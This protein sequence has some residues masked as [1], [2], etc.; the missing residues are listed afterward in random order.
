MGI[1]FRSVI[2]IAYKTPIQN[3]H[4]KA[5]VAI[6]LPQAIRHRF[7]VEKPSFQSALQDGRQGAS[8]A[9]FRSGAEI[10]RVACV[11]VHR[12]SYPLGR[13][14]IFVR[15]AIGTARKAPFQNRHFDPVGARLHSDISG[16]AA[17]FLSESVVA[18]C[19]C[20]RI[21]TPFAQMGITF[22]SVIRIAYKT[23]IQN[24]HSEAP[25]APLLPLKLPRLEESLAGTTHGVGLSRRSK[26]VFNSARDLHPRS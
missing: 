19:R 10:R 18:G 22:R 16:P 3:R 9:E 17:I 14:R 15:P 26:V 12:L 4:S 5:P 2:R 23:P 20:D 24:R 25:V 6:L 1:T 11:L 13:T 21:Q 8:F 7:R